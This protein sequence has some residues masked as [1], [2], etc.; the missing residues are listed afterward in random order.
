MGMRLVPKDVMRVR[1]ES[2]A[3]KRGKGDEKWKESKKVKEQ[4]EERA[5]AAQRWF[6]SFLP[7]LPS[8]HPF[9]LLPL[10]VHPSFH[11]P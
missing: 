2:E 6:P 8:L 3:E 11:P 7:F 9:L 5:S 4:K 1:D 10:S